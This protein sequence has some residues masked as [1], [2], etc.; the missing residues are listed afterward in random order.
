MNVFHHLGWTRLN[1]FK[2]SLETNYGRSLIK[3]K[4]T[5]SRPSQFRYKTIDNTI[6]F[7]KSINLNRTVTEF[8]T[9]WKKRKNHIQPLVFL[10]KYGPTHVN[11]NNVFCSS[12]LHLHFDSNRSNAEKLAFS[13]QYNTQNH[14]IALFPRQWEYTFFMIDGCRFV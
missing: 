4:L 3:K 1:T 11:N 12:F 5:N 2:P 14:Q 6:T 8:H 7:N 9:F 10:M 13:I